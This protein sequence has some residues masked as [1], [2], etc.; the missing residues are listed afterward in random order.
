[1]YLATTRKLIFTFF[2]SDVYHRNNNIF[3]ISYNCL[4][5]TLIQ[6]SL[7]LPIYEYFR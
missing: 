6:L 5:I 2:Y 1:M 3:K 7:R 4:F